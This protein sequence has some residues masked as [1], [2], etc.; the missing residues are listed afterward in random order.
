MN[1]EFFSLIASLLTGFTIDVQAAVADEAGIEARIDAIAA[2][3]LER[4]GAV[5]LSIG[6]ARAGKVLIAKG[7]GFADLEFDVR[8]DA[9]TLFRIGSVTKQFTA[10]LV[11][12]YVEQ[13]NLALDD[14]ISKYVP[15]FPM[16][17]KHVTVEQLL[18][19]T[20]GIPSYTDQGEAW[21]AK[22][23]LELTHDEL[24]GIVAG[25]P[26]DFEPGTQWAYNN[27]AYYMLGM[28]VEKVSGLPYEEALATELLEPLGLGR[29]RRD[30]NTDLVK[31]RAQ[32]Y[33]LAGPG[34]VVNDQ[35]LGTNQPGAAGF[36]LSTGSD[37]VRWQ[38]AL[39]SGNVVSSESFA[40]MTTPTV[41]QSGKS[42]GYGFGLAI[43][44][45]A[46][47]RRIQHGG[48]IF[49]FNSMLLWIPDDDL[50][51]AV[52]SNGEPLSSA[53]IADEITL[54]VLGIAKPPIRDEPV[55]AERMELLAGE[56]RIEAIGLDARVFVRDGKLHL[57]ATGQSDFRLLWQTGGEFRASF[58]DDVKVVFADDGQ[59]FTLHQGGGVFPAKRIE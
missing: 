37:L 21:R 27:T 11:M 30:S 52:V 15:T 34:L 14:E 43:D 19:H 2:E 31:N 50:H 46:G 20:S 3:N 24:L 6:V 45:F 28:I 1:V 40:R 26:F 35:V 13:G 54:A 58:D 17:G 42:T 16:Q 10:A 59:S 47:K 32:G 53:K 55:P 12:S 33:T 48:G 51:V 5:G 44:E 39:T 18:T 4:P 56:Y 36:L 23:P 22:W 8:A 29:T 49:G 38:M 9:E 7:Y 57:Q 41:L 25:K